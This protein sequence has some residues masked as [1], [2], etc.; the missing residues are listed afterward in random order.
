MMKEAPK[1]L[2]SKV[3][4]RSRGH[5]QMSLARFYREEARHIEMA[6]INASEQEKKQ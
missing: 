3:M 2:M 6:W 4:L 1:A 5:A